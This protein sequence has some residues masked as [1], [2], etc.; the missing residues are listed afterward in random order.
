MGTVTSVVSIAAGPLAGLVNSSAYRK[1]RPAKMPKFEARKT[2][3]FKMSNLENGQE[4][5]G[6]YGPVNPNED[7]SV[8]WQTHTTLGRQNPILQY[9]HGNANTFT[10]TAYFYS[11]NENDSIAEKSLDV[12]RSWT[13]RDQ[14]LGRPPRVSFTVGDGKMAMPEAVITS[15]GIA[16]YDPPKHS[17]GIR[18]V[19]IAVSLMQ[20]TQFSLETTVLGE[21]R[22]HR[23]KTNEYYEL[24][25]YNEYNSALLGDVIRK[26]HPEQQELTEGD[27]VKLPSIQVIRTEKVEPKSIPFYKGYTTKET[28]TRSLRQEVF[29]R[30]NFNYF[31]AIIPAGL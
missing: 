13:R 31:S 18:A 30:N 14:D 4:L 23:V 21:T 29:A 22:Y 7:I 11:A 19:S 25:T 2:H 10:F 27:T 15:L 26:R 6:Q 24:I 12:L 20:Y 9:L 17:G 28:D 5:K 1:A 16:Y 8:S 3:P